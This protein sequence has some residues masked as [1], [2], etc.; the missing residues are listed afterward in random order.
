MK[1]MKFNALVPELYVSD[2]NKSLHFYIDILGFKLEY[3]RTNPN[4]AFLS[5][6]EA[7]LMIQEQELSDDHTGSLKYPY[8]RGINFEIETPD[9]TDIINSLKK[10]NYSLKK[11]LK[12]Y[13][14]KIANGVLLGSREIQVLDPDGYFLRFSEKIKS[15]SV[16]E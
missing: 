1:I 9:I 4:F 10:Y 2:Y 16:E 15:S 14:R 8:G 12:E 3:D 6:G 7:Q 5:H 13:Q 11:E